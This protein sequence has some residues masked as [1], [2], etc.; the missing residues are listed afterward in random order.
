M[1]KRVASIHVYDAL[2]LVRF[3]G[4]VRTYVGYDRDGSTVTL[5]FHGDLPSRGSDDEREWLRDALLVLLT[6]L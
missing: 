3:S 2:T 5:E 1:A 6:T 4:Q